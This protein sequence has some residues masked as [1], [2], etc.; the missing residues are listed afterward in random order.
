MLVNSSRY[1]LS[2]ISRKGDSMGH[3]VSWTL[4]PKMQPP[5]RIVTHKQ[6]KRSPQHKEGVRSSHKKHSCSWASFEI[7]PEM[8]SWCSSLCRQIKATIINCLI[9][10]VPYLIDSICHSCFGLGQNKSRLRS[11]N[12]LSHPET[13]GKH[14]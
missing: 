1:S 4:G 9:P 2:P 5:S 6:S 14:P 10:P 13:P 11:G 3:C 8:C 12:E 7:L